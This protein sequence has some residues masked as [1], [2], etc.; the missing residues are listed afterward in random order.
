MPTVL[1]VQALRNFVISRSSG[2]SAA[3]SRSHAHRFFAA[4]ACRLPSLT[5]CEPFALADF[6]SGSSVRRAPKGLA[7]GLSP[8]SSR[9]RLV[10]MRFA[11]VPLFALLDLCVSSLRRG[12]ADLLCIVP[13]F[14][15]DPRRESD[16]ACV[17]LL[18]VLVGDPHTHAD[19]D[20]VGH[21]RLEG[22]RGICM[23]IYIYIYI[24]IY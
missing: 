13:S 17:P 12:H 22:L 14:T 9:A 15:D 11:R 4:V 3:C 5:V 18:E 19:E 21:L 23:H 2:P 24:Y 16:F 10:W 20:L 6:V 1:V 8:A 7:F